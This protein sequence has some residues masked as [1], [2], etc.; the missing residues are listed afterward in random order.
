MGCLFLLQMIFLL[1]EKMLGMQDQT[2]IPII[3]YLAGRFFTTETAGETQVYV[4]MYVCMYVNDGLRRMRKMDLN[5]FASVLYMSYSTCIPGS[6]LSMFL[7]HL[8]FFW[9]RLQAS[10]HM[11]I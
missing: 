10:M 11:G 4:C 3:S 8:T 6:L 7:S 2:H 9:C 5:G 1:L